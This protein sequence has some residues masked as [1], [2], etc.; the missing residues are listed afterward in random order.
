MNKLA[1]SFPDYGS[2]NIR[3]Y[4]FLTF[5]LNAWFFMPNWV[6]YFNQFISIKEIALL[7]GTAKVLQIFMEIPS[8]AIADLLGYKKR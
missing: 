5:F 4:Y 6:F 8:G 2:R 7:S 3:L 1:K